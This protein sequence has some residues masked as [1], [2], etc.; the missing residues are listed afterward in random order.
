M[1]IRCGYCGPSASL[2]AGY[3]Y[4]ETRNKCL[5]KGFG[6]GIGVEKRK[7][8][9]KLGLPMDPPFVSPCP[10][11]DRSLI[12]RVKSGNRSVSSSR[13]P[14]RSPRR[15]RKSRSPKRSSKRSPRRSSRRRSV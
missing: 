12:R 5:Q 15:S 14:K 7:W 8:Q 9:R 11:K 2:P 4:F 3:D 1:S 13:S 6:S 10:K